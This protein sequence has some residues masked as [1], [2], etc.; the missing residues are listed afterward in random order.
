MLVLTFTPSDLAGILCAIRLTHIAEPGSKNGM[1][2]KLSTVAILTSD[3]CHIQAALPTKV[4]EW[5]RA[6]TYRV[7]MF[8]LCFLM[9]YADTTP[10]NCCLSPHQET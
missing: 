10:L 1:P 9:L 8:M 5:R 4:R 7:D 2:F 6:T 3:A